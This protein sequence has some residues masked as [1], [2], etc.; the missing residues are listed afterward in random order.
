MHAQHLPERILFLSRG[1]SSVRM[2]TALLRTLGITAVAHMDD[3]HK[4]VS[5]LCQ[6]LDRAHSDASVPTPDLV[7]CDTLVGGESSMVFLHLAAE[8]PALCNLPYLLFSG[9]PSQTAVLQDA[10]LCTL[11]RPFTQAQL[12][13]H[14]LAATGPKRLPLQKSLLPTRRK[15][16]RPAHTTPPVVTTSDM[17]AKALL[18]WQR[19]DYAGAEQLFLK[20]LARQ[21][22]HIEACLGL[23]SLHRARTNEAEAQRYILRAA[24]ASLRRNRPEQATYIAESLPESMRTGNLFAY[25]ALYRLDAGEYRAAAHGFLEAA[26]HQP[27]LPLH[28]IMARACQFTTN[29]EASL[30]KISDALELMGQGTTAHAL[31]HRLLSSH[32][33][34]QQD[35][36]PTWLDNFPLLKEA[37][38]VASYTTRAWRHA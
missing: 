21:D 20:V 25:E 5:A 11:E 3:P 16:P 17:Y 9:T 31:R 10:G 35:P 7:L 36:P 8:H 15:S 12:R 13:E 32:E 30:G 29:P 26:A 34:Q 14:L 24:T 38:S 22:D 18:L 4:A 19:Q 1:E 6:V 33:T 28:G 37:V 27:G 2:D 23:A